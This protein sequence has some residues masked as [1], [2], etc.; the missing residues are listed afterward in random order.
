MQSQIRPSC[1]SCRQRGQVPHM[2]ESSQETL[3]KLR[4]WA[5]PSFIH[6]SS[7]T[8]ETKNLQQLLIINA[9]VSDRFLSENLRAAARSPGLFLKAAALSPLTR[10]QAHR[11]GSGERVTRRPT[12][13]CPDNPDHDSGR[14]RGKG[15]RI[16]AIGMQARQR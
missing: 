8:P 10:P 6:Q 9:V 15:G 7:R 4:R 14:Q 13:F 12:V 1:A 3:L 2:P 5:L 11:S 16:E